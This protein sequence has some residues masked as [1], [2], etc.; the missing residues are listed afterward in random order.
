[1]LLISSIDCFLIS[2]LSR[3]NELFSAITN[4]LLIFFE[5]NYSVSIFLMMFYQI[6]LTQ[7]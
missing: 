3:R 2:K 7:A 1:M 6:Q 5:K 4:N